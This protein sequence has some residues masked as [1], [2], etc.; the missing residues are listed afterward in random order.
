MRGDVESN[1]YQ[2]GPVNTYHMEGSF[3]TRMGSIKKQDPGYERFNSDYEW[4]GY[5]FE[6]FINDWPPNK[7]N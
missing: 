2:F 1:N 6:K 5:P 4:A 7:F 3:Q